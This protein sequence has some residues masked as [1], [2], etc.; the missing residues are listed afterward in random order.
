MG[1]IH[2]YSKLR[3]RAA[4][5]VGVGIHVRWLS[6]ASSF[7]PFKYSSFFLSLTFLLFWQTQ[8]RQEITPGYYAFFL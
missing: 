4:N 8:G 3:A 5:R 1:N 2:F 6:G 7:S